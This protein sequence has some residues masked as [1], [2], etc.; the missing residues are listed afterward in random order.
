[1]LSFDL[2]TGCFIEPEGHRG[3]IEALD[4]LLDA[5]NS[6]RTSETGYITSLKKLVEKHPAYLDAHAHLGFALLKLG[7]SKAALEACETGVSI[8]R[9]LVPENYDGLIEW[10]RHENR[11]FLRMMHA[12]T[13]ALLAAKKRPQ[14]IER[15]ER[16]LKWNPGDNQGLRFILG[17][18]LLREGHIKPARSRLESYA[19]EYPPAWYELGLLHFRQKDFALAAHSFRLGFL[20]NGYIAEVLTGTPSPLPLAIWH[21]SNFA[22]PDMARDYANRQGDLWNKTPAAIAFLRWL[23]MHP[24]A[25]RERASAIDIQRALLWEVDYKTRSALLDQ[26]STLSASID[27]ASSAELVRPVAMSGKRTIYPWMAGEARILRS[28]M[29]RK[30]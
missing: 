27:L 8:G 30:Q 13:L 4:T 6:G 21:G 22:E 29:A 11:P 1:M 28:E 17:P 10:G 7:K 12:S 15:M 3:A 5:R 18:E 20:T 23:H 19:E 24:T 25:L 14:A 16:L 9:A 26:L 2:Q